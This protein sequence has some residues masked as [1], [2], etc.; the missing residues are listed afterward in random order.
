MTR[1]LDALRT[2]NAIQRGVGVRDHDLS[3]L[4]MPRL[5]GVSDQAVDARELRTT[6][7]I[8]GY[9]DQ[10]IDRIVAE[11]HE[12]YADDARRGEVGQVRRR[13]G[14]GAP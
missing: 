10:V 7:A 4:A 11:G 6:A 3:P 9:V 2:R 14:Q 12:P 1:P 13:T 8:R 5:A